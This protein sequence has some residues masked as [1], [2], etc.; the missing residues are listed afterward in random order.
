MFGGAKYPDNS[1]NFQEVKRLVKWV[2]GRGLAVKRVSEG[3]SD[4]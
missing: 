3:V 4:T 1:Q 2:S